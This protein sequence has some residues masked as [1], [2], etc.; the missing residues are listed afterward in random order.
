MQKKTIEFTHY[1]WLGVCPVLIAFGEN[2][3]T[4]IDARFKLDW[5]LWTS[6]FLSN[7]YSDLNCAI[8]YPHKP[9]FC[10]KVSGKFK[11]PKKVKAP[12][13]SKNKNKK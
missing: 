11:K 13:Y 4:I 1:G 5:L 9:E 2:D 8:H 6:V 7:L 3:E 12:D 10:I